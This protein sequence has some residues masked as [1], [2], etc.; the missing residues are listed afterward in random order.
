MELT[1]IRPLHGSA[2]IIVKTVVK[3]VDGMSNMLLWGW[4]PPVE[5]RAQHDQT[6][7]TGTNLKI[8]QGLQVSKLLS[9][10]H[11]K[12][13]NA[14][15]LEPPTSR[16]CCDHCKDNCEDSRWLEHWAVRYLCVSGNA[17]LL[18]FD[19]LIAWPW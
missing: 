1:W 14:T 17:V 7:R 8:E 19:K 10:L 16:R 9:Y 13:R 3:T 15:Y 6:Y 12:P 18:K 4:L 5:Y 2:A 11:Y